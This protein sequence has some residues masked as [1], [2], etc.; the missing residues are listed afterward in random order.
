MQDTGASPVVAVTT[1]SQPSEEFFLLP[2]T[3]PDLLEI[4]KLRKE[5]KT[6]KAKKTHGGLSDLV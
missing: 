1:M 5:N 6:R 4:G 3:G 2:F